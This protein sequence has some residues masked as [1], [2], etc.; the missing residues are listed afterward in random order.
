MCLADWAGRKMWG[1]REREDVVRDWRKD[2]K[3]MGEEREEEMR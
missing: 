3:D 2:G 1:R